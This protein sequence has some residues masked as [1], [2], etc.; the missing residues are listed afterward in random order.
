MDKE[1]DIRKADAEEINIEIPDGGSMD[2]GQS[3]LL[4]ELY[5]KE[6][7]NL[8]EM[9]YNE[10]HDEYDA[11]DVAA[12]VLVYILRHR[13]WWEKQNE[14][15]RLEYAR[16]TCERIC[17]EFCQKRS[18]VNQVEFHES[19]PK[20]GIDTEFER[21]LLE[22]ENL[23]ELFDCLKEADKEIFIARYIEGRSVKSIAAQ[24]NTA[25]NNISKRLSRGRKLLKEHLQENTADNICEQ[26]EKA[27]PPSK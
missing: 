11:E 4:E 13:V 21:G 25:E 1:T 12:E 23:L 10:L 16:K 2:T 8:F 5:Q 24:H 6:H 7:K 18:R 15:V 9:A 22:N 27:A 26:N 3:A 20:K 17:S 14:S 19:K